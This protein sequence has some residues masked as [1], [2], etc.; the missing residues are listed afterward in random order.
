M[1]KTM[2]KKYASLIVHVG[3]NVQKGQPVSLHAAVDQ[4]EFAA[5]VAE[6]CYKA[7]AS[8]VD[9]EWRYQPMTKLTYKYRTLKSLSAVPAWEEEKM[10]LMTEEIPCQI[11]IES[12]DPDGLRGINRE[13]MQK[14]RMAVY[15]IKKK[16]LDAIEN[17]DQWTIAAVP[18]VEWAKKV[19]PGVSGKRACE[20]LWDAILQSV[21]VTKDND[22]VKEWNAHNS[23]LAERC[24]WLN[25][26]HFEYLHYTS[27]NGTDFRASLIPEGRWC[28]GGENSLQGIFFNPNLPTEEIFTTP[29][30]GKAEGTL[31]STKPLSYQGQMIENFRITFRDGKAAEWDAE[32]GRD[33]LD[34]MLS[35]DEG[36]P[37]LGELAL[38]PKTSPIAESGILFYNTLFD[39][40]ASC[41]VALGRGFMDCIDNFQNRTLEEC[42]ALG[43]ND[44]MI[45][46]DFMIGTDDLTVTG[47][48]DGKATPIFVNGNWADG[49]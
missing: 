13:K 33:L 17:K 35:M 32:T 7:G 47:Y 10:K 37:Y 6:E 5:M 49:V 29:M 11:H 20:M 45:H 18:S 15:P 21:R 46:V 42:R 41:H 9:M 30:R 14:A 2:M 34:R 12:E 39:E 44:S 16:Y 3:A 28:G 26:Q 27:A 22:P 31:V 8:R 25:S 4:A 36:A 38:S 43:V 23:R 48:K 1:T 19:F 24:A 40:N